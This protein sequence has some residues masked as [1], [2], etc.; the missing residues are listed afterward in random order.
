MPRRFQPSEA[1]DACGCANT[2]S[3]R[4]DGKHLPPAG[5]VALLADRFTQAHRNSTAVVVC[6]GT[7]TSSTRWANHHKRPQSYAV[8]DASAF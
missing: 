1:G 2:G 4:T 8:S 7:R 5:R 3:Y 6:S